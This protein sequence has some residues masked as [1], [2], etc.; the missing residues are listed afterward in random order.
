MRT[1]GT[2]VGYPE[3][4]GVRRQSY[5]FRAQADFLLS[6]KTDCGKLVEKLWMEK[7]KWYGYESGFRERK[8]GG[9]DPSE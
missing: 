7:V 3:R 4:F 9:R 5:S 2:A 1:D 6:L 8:D